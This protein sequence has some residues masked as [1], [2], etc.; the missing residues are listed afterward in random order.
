MVSLEAQLQESHLDY[1]VPPLAAA[2]AAADDDDDYGMVLVLAAGPSM[3]LVEAADI[4]SPAS[5]SVL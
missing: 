4:H 5:S 2:A 1:L 3:K